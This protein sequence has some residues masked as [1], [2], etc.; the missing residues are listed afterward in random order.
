MTNKSRWHLSVG[1]R[2]VSGRCKPPTLSFEAE[3]T[4]GSQLPCFER[5][6]TEV[7]WLQQILRNPETLNSSRTAVGPGIFVQRK[8]DNPLPHQFLYRGVP[9]NL[10]SSMSIPSHHPA[11]TMN[12]PALPDPA[13]VEEVMKACGCKEDQAIMVLQVISGRNIFDVSDYYG[14]SALTTKSNA[15]S[16]NIRY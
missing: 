4:H 1:C 3:L 8:L 13:L 14:S 15:Q 10:Y 2:C 11:H 5:K 12:S 9:E 7:Y 6:I 16:D